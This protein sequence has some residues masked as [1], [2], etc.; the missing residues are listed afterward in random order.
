[1]SESFEILKSI[2]RAANA[3]REKCGATDIALIA[4]SGLGGFA[5]QLDNAALLPYASIPGFP[6]STVP[7]HAGTWV[8]GDVGGKR[9]ALMNGRVHSYEGHDAQTLAFPVRV[10][11]R[12][13]VKTLIVTNAA[14]G[15]NKLY[16]PGDFMLIA[17]FINLAG[18]NPLR[19]PNIDEIGTRFPDMSKALDPELR[20]LARAKARKLDFRVSEG[21]YAMMPGPSFETPAEIRML[22]TLGADAAGMSTVPEIITA[23]HAGMRVL[24]ISC[25]TNMAAGILDQ[26][27]NHKEV[28]E[29]GEM[30]KERFTE[31]MKEIIGSL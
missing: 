20:D 28:L 24:G 2:D 29:T 8:A 5:S 10:M 9:I 21:V 18:I 11:A 12:L 19:G 23:R 17:D 4:G 25:I 15:V 31:W 27:L 22:Y 30:V 13:G 3:I 26:P 16:R 1:M 6:R 7:G 14:G